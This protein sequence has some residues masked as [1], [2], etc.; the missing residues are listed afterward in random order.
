VAEL[1]VSVPEREELRVIISCVSQATRVVV[2]A[3]KRGGSEDSGVK[4]REDCVK[5]NRLAEHVEK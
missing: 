4:C 5:E 2:S 3:G 1:G